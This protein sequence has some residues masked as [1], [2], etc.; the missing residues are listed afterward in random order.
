MLGTKTYLTDGSGAADFLHRGPCRFA[1][2]EGRGEQRS[3]ATRAEAI[4]LR[5]APVARVEGVNISIGKS[6][7]IAVFRSGDE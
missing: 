1:M 2:L 5:Y 3:F 7:G 6:I 4:G